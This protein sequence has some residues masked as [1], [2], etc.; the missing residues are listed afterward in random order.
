MQYRP[1]DFSAILRGGRLFQQYIVDMWASAEH[2]RLNY[3]RYH[4]AE[5]CASV[6]SGLEDAING[7][8]NVDLHQLGQRV[9]LPSSFV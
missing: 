6:Y 8:D 5:L 3:L 9:I 2:S 1:G 7:A 4:Q